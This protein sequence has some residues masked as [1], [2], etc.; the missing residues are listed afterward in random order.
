MS[1]E[2]DDIVSGFDEYEVTEDDGEFLVQD[3][4]SEI[5]KK[6]YPGEV[7]TRDVII[8]EAIDTNGHRIF[9]YQG[10]SGV[11]PW[12]ILGMIKYVEA[13]INEEIIMGP[14]VGPVEDDDND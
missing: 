8:T 12:D 10:S 4:L 14:Y 6:L 2:F 1:D 11:M 3:L 7:L 5:H 13:R 9:R